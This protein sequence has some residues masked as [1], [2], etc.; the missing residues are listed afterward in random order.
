LKT[1]V[2]N[3][4]ERTRVPFLRGILIRSLTEA[5]LAFDQA[6]SLATTIRESLSE[7]AEISSQDLYELTAD[8]LDDIADQSVLAHYLQPATVPARILVK[9]CSG[10]VSAFSRG[11]HM[12]YLQASG[13]TADQSEHTTS[14]VYEQ[15]LVA[16]I[17]SIDTGHL[18]YLTYLCLQQEI[19]AHAADRYLVWADFQRSG[20]PLQLLIGGCVGSGKSSVATGTAHR[21]DIVRTQSTD[22][23]REVMRKMMPKRLLPVLHVSSFDAWKQVPMGDRK[24]RDKDQLIADGFRSQ[25]ELLAI[26]CEAVLQRAVRESVPII[27]EGTHAH[28]AL[29]RR[30]PDVKDAITVFVTL[31]VLSSRELKSRLRGRGAEVPQRRAKRYLNKFD[32]IW[33]LQTFLLSEADRY[34][35]PI[36]NND[37]IEKAIHQT[38]TTVNDELK[39]HFG[40]EP[41][42][43]FGGIVGEFT[44]SG[45]SGDWKELAQVLKSKCAGQP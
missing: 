39:K 44:A 19:G 33:R 21:L 3:K 6:F 35:V 14:Q 17:D 27:L 38:I 16:G 18:A 30:A 13:L 29:L 11:I 28:P 34:D 32:S 42:I 8:Y 43:V 15:L 2:V 23:L 7:T 45:E 5:G 25:V 37:D 20:R 36:I 10:H 40:E 31:A 1:F 12:R 4:T 22:M 41:G 9:N 24:G 26:P